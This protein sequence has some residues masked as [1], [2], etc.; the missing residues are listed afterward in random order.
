MI[1]D[2]LLIAI[3]LGVLYVRWLWRNPPPERNDDGA[4]IAWIGQ[5]EVIAKVAAE[6]ADQIPTDPRIPLRV[7]GDI[8]RRQNGL[9]R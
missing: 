1:A 7:Y 6:Q 9:D 8:Y 2:L 3:V 5:D 4:G